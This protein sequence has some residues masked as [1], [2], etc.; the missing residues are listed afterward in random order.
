MTEPELPTATVDAPR[1]FRIPLVWI[2]PLVA[3]LIG[4]FLAARTS[5]QRPS[6]CA[7]RTGCW[8]PTRASGWSARACPA[9]R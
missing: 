9:V 1:R 6:W 4:V 5:S 7:K 3:L 8:W 2:I